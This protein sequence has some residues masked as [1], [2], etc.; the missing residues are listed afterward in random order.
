M[1]EPVQKRLARIIGE[2]KG[3]YD[4]S[5]LYKILDEVRISGDG[6][7]RALKDIPLGKAPGD[8][9]FWIK[10]V[11]DTKAVPAISSKGISKLGGN[12]SYAN[13]VLTIP[14]FRALYFNTDGQ[15]EIKTFLNSTFTIDPALMTHVVV[16]STGTLVTKETVGVNDTI[17]VMMSWKDIPIAERPA[18]GFIT[19]NEFL[20]AKPLD[21][22][23]EY[24]TV[25]KL[26]DFG[27][28]RGD[29]N[30]VVT[31]F[32]R[33]NRFLPDGF[34][35]FIDGDY[36]AN[37]TCFINNKSCITVIGGRLFKNTFGW[38]GE[39]LLRFEN[40]IE[41]KLFGTGLKGLHGESRNS[42]WGEQGC[43]FR[44]CKGPTIKS[45]Y[46]ESFGDAGLRFHSGGYDSATVPEKVASFDTRIEG[47]FFKYVQQNTMTPG[48]ATRTIW[49]GNIFMSSG[50][51]AIKVASRVQDS[52]TVI[53]A[54]NIVDDHTADV[55]QF[56][57]GKRIHVTGNLV[58]RSN[59]FVALSSNSDGVNAA[60][61][62]PVCYE[63]TMIND[64][65]VLDMTGRILYLQNRAFFLNGQNIL[66][67]TGSL[68][69]CGNYFKQKNTG[70]E[71]V[72]LYVDESI[73]FFSHTVTGEGGSKIQAPIAE[74]IQISNNIFEN[75]NQLF[76]LS[77]SVLNG[78]K[79]FIENNKALNYSKDFCFW[80]NISSLGQ[81]ASGTEIH[82]V[83][84]YTNKCSNFLTLGGAVKT[85]PVEYC[86]I[87][88]NKCRNL[89]EGGI[90]TKSTDHGFAL[91]LEI[92]GNDLSTVDNFVGS[93][94]LNIVVGDASRGIKGNLK[95]TNNDL[96]FKGTTNTARPVYIDTISQIVDH[97]CHSNFTKGST[98]TSRSDSADIDLTQLAI[99]V[100]A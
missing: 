62:D 75:G 97:F 86:L 55:F 68:I 76:R 36:A 21:S 96:W 29:G 82:F 63:E 79:C 98:G 23:S 69:M 50:G 67:M 57:G 13:G 99:T 20:Q 88:N 89:V 42:V 87:K 51:A 78:M 35:L 9:D 34:T 22:D 2:F 43:Y 81:D 94:L 1:T 64:N 30:S 17:V 19:V 10:T 54:G 37:S 95:L 32:D 58:C 91:D 24:G 52:D 6:V 53:I 44:A 45:C 47:N 15:L 85:L 38:D 4:S 60:Y 66:P 83:N 5:G 93:S 18:A 90:N 25:V 71:A 41:P 84:N 14:R 8:L 70:T 26:S 48:G 61:P 11:S 40:C 56:Q 27:A 3:E 59:T 80:E 100:L 73:R 74:L 49:T 39:Y 31:A 92:I 12:L 33:V 46:F 65:V 28:K 77:S 72:P 7:Y 16:D